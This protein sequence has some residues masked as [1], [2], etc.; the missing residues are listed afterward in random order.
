MFNLDPITQKE[1]VR[2]L[3]PTALGCIAYMAAT[4]AAWC[5]SPLPRHV[6]IGRLIFLFL[7]MLVIWVFYL[8]S[9]AIAFSGSREH[10]YALGGAAR[11]MG[12]YYGAQTLWIWCVLALLKWPRRGVPANNES[13]IA[14]S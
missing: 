6:Y 11:G 13:T 10:F 7:F 5:I 14:D 1:I 4:L 12:T 2:F 9:A 3:I 8:P